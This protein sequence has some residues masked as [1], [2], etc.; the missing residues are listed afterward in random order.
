M[1][2]PEYDELQ[3]KLEEQIKSS[4]GKEKSF[5]DGILFA[6]SLLAEI[7]ERDYGTKI[8]I[9]ELGLNKFMVDG[10]YVDISNCCGSGVHTVYK[11][12]WLGFEYYMRYESN[13]V[14]LI[15]KYDYEHIPF[16]VVRATMIFIL[17][18]E[19]KSY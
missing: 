9:K 18:N 11:C 4:S 14:E 5:I 15:K 10:N 12:E 1:T 17:K 3:F 7:F 2:K 8:E 13:G 16:R 19:H 6:K